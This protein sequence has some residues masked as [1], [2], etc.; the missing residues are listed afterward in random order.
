MRSVEARYCVRDCAGIRACTCTG[1]YLS[2]RVSAHEQLVH[3]HP[4]RHVHWAAHVG[5]ELFEPPKVRD[6]HLH[7]DIG[8]SGG[9]YALAP[10]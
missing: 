10:N 6:L 8:V 7:A 2:T 1:L 4:I 3:H 9:Q 5:G